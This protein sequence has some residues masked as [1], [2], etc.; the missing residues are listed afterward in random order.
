MVPQGKNTKGLR[1]VVTRVQKVKSG[2]TR[3]GLYQVPMGNKCRERRS[4]QIRNFV[5]VQLKGTTVK[6]RG[7]EK[8]NNKDIKVRNTTDSV[9]PVVTSL[10]NTRAHQSTRK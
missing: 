4:F 8:A 1:I 6:L 2:E 10:S 3:Y 7:S 9:G 5:F